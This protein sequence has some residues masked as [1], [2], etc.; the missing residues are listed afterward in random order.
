VWLMNALASVIRG[1]GNMFVPSMAICIGVVLLIPLS[2]MLIFGFGPIPAMGI[3]G[4]GTAVLLTTALT[5]GV[6]A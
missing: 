1:T 3:E 4:G 2:P 6:L 5:A